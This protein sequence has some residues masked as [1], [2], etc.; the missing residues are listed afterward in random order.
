MNQINEENSYR[1]ERK[2]N[3]VGLSASEIENIVKIHP[4]MFSEIFHKRYV[5]NIYFD[6]FNYSNFLQN[7][8]GQAKRNKYR[9]RWYGD[10]MGYIEK[11]VLEIKVRQGYVGKKPIFAIKPFIV[12]EDMNVDV[13]LKSIDSSSLPDEVMLALNF[14]KPV[15]AN[16]YL[17]KY[18]KSAD[19]KFRITIDSDVS[20]FRMSGVNFS[21]KHKLTDF[22]TIVMEIKYNIKDEDKISD[23]TSAFPFRITRNSKYVN[24]IE[25]LYLY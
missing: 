17:R 24:G 9:I 4:A 10:F 25:N 18:F 5:N 19:D 1:Y 13:I 20:Y 6:D 14:Q 12:K 3:V 8:S 22:E 11:P 15:L 23:I 16:R 2:F 7:L 21:F